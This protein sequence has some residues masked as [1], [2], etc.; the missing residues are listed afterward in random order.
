MSRRRYGPF[1]Y[2]DLSHENGRGFH[3]QGSVRGIVA[4]D[5]V[6]SPSGRFMSPEGLAD[7]T[8]R[9]RGYGT[10]VD[11][12]GR[13]IMIAPEGA[14]TNH[15]QGPGARARQGGARPDLSNSNT[16][17]ISFNSNE[18]QYTPDQIQVARY[19]L[20][21]YLRDRYGI[22]PGD[23]SNVLRHP[24]VQP[25]KNSD[26]GLWRNEIG[27][28]PMQDRF[29]G[30]VARNMHDAAQLAQHGNANYKDEP[31]I[32][33]R[34]MNQRALTAGMAPPNAPG[35]FA[36]VKSPPPAVTSGGKPFEE[37]D[38]PSIASAAQ[39]S[40][41]EASPG[42]PFSIA[43]IPSFDLQTPALAK[44][45]EQEQAPIDTSA[46]KAAIAAESDRRS[47][48]AITPEEL[49]RRLA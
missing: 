26:E 2:E 13:I 43:S 42:A 32:A 10:M 19:H 36:E 28:V 30:N 17:A 34:P 35:P 6:G 14:S 4:H 18:G 49:R 21:S 24:E 45:D 38:R 7:W 5:V 23:L 25:N 29:V 44:R 37:I 16:D 9:R 22:K 48:F 47:K 12:D 20:P 33:A 8:A 40:S 1:E 39:P 15:I 27:Y 11:R 3:S 31:I 46:L 41:V